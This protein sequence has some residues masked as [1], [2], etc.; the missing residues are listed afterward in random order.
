MS[1]L[2][3]SA[4][5]VVGGLTM[6]LAGVGMV[7]MPDLFSRMQAATK[8]AT[9]GVGSTLLGVAVCFGSLSVA[10]RALLIIALVFLTAPIAAHVIA[11]AAHAVGVPYWHGTLV[12]ESYPQRPGEQLRE[13][14][15]RRDRPQSFDPPHH[16]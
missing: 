13:L 16:G 11:R 10:F 3:G 1:D 5:L 15:Q 12:D 8:A 4:L 2:I 7:R 9:L 14:R 6:L